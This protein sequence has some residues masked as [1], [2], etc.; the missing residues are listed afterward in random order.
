M[1]ALNGY[2]SPSEHISSLYPSVFWISRTDQ[3]FQIAQ[4]IEHIVI[5]GSVGKEDSAFGLF[6]LPSLLTV[7]I[8]CGAFCNSHL[9]V[10]K[11]MID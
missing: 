11:S 4:T 7:D 2:V 10:F 5:Q 8:G 6:Y 3:M 9:I 1:V